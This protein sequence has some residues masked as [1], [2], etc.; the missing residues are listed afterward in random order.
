MRERAQ[1]KAWGMGKRKTIMNGEIKECGEMWRKKV[2][3]EAEKRERQSEN[4]EQIPPE[5]ACKGM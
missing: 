1:V 5:I 4:V 2:K 3:R